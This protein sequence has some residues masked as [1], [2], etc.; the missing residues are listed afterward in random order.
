MHLRVARRIVVLAFMGVI[1]STAT[2]AWAHD[3]RGFDGITM[4]VGWLNEPTYSGSVNAVQVALAQQAGG[5]IA[6]AKLSVVVVFGK[7]G[8]PT[9]SASLTLEPSD[10]T[11]GEYTAAIVPT[12]PGQ[13]SFHI[14]GAA[15]GHKIDEWFQSSETTFDNVSD[16]TA[17]EFPAKD[18]TAG[19]LAQRVSASDSKTK[20]ASTRGTI[21][22]ALA[23]V[24]IVIGGVAL[25]RKRA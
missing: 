9:H 5:P 13:Y 16:P 1:I 17:D 10:E 3:Q 15:A 18:P 25:A 22:L 12:R 14:T 6:D 21:A 8:S 11:P 7:E 19:Q 20:S 4:R 24:A 23:V 2:A